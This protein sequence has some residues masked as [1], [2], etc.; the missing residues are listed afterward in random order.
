M[1]KELYGYQL[2]IAYLCRLSNWFLGAFSWD[3][4]LYRFD[5][6]QVSTD[7]CFTGVPTSLYKLTPQQTYDLLS[8]GTIWKLSMTVGT[9]EKTGIILRNLIFMSFWVVFF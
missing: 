8:F 4:S 1:R 6:G 5:G 3:L 9:S 2:G 7:A